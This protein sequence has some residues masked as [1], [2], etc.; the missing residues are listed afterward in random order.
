VTWDRE[1]PRFHATAVSIGR[2]ASQREL[3]RIDGWPDQGR[4]A[5]TR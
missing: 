5:P 4:T 3:E 1:D 2:S